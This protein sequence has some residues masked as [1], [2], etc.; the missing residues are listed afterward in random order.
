LAASFSWENKGSNVRHTTAAQRALHRKWSLP[1]H[2]QFPQLYHGWNIYQLSRSWNNNKGWKWGNKVSWTYRLQVP[3]HVYKLWCLFFFFFFFLFYFV[4]E[5]Y[6]KPN[7]EPP[8][9]PPNPLT[10]GPISV[11]QLWCHHC[12]INDFFPR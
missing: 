10:T 6:K 1:V 2:Q 11:A 7:L 9:K 3:F 12:Q 4:F 8:K 5:C